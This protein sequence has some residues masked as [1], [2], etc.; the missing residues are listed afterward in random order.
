MQK[1]ASKHLTWIA[2]G[3]FSSAVLYSVAKNW[4]VV[5]EI[6]EQVKHNIELSLSFQDFLKRLPE[7]QPHLNVPPPTEISASSEKL[8]RLNT[9]FAAIAL[10]VTWVANYKFEEFFDNDYAPAY[11]G[12]IAATLFA[13]VHIASAYLFRQQM[14]K[15]LSEQQA[16]LY[17]Q[18][19]ILHLMSDDHES[20]T[21]MFNEGNKLS[22]KLEGRCLLS[23]PAPVSAAVLRFIQLPQVMVAEDDKGYIRY[24]KEALRRAN[25]ARANALYRA[26]WGERM[27]RQMREQVQ[28]VLCNRDN[29]IRYFEHRLDRLLGQNHR[30]RDELNCSTV[31]GDWL[32]FPERQWRN[33][34]LYRRRDIVEH[35]STFYEDGDGYYVEENYWRRSQVHY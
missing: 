20:A 25:N 6:T 19:G 35:E 14:K 26:D 2:G 17:H 29:Q 27:A 31:H 12:V 28:G 11:A 13:V 33:L 1:D 22:H 4:G 18:R 24:L 9:T 5:G 34:T 21:C 8:A 16:L 7:L 23:P 10:I 32:E 3:A 15:L 30:V